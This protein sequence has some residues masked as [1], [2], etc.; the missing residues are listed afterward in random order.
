MPKLHS[1]TKDVMHFLWFQSLLV[2]AEI[3]LVALTENFRTELNREIP[4]MLFL[5]HDL[6]AL[7]DPICSPG[8]TWNWVEAF[9]VS[10]VVPG[11]LILSLALRGNCCMLVACVGLL[12]CPLV[13]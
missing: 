3:A 13:I 8:P 7:F 9:E 1:S 11:G 6:S 2:G 10:S 5:L 12:S 4:T